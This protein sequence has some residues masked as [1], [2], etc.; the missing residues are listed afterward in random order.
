MLYEK[1]CCRVCVAAKHLL[2]IIFVLLFE[3]S[4]STRNESFEFLPEK[5][6]KVM[7][8]DNVNEGKLLNT[9]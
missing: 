9:N 3:N 8:Q 7:G 4:G 5:R 6:Q 2:T 1:V